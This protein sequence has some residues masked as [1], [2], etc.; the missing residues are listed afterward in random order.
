M[1]FFARSSRTTGP[2]IRVPTGSLCI[3]EDDG[4]V[5]VEAD[6]GAVFA[7]NFLG[8]AHD[9]GLA[10]VALLHAAARD[11]F[12]DRHHDDVANGCVTAVEPPRTLMH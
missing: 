5:A 6:R 2:K 3:V 1:K 8:G 4:G 12:L 7:A 9:D 11:G 10:H